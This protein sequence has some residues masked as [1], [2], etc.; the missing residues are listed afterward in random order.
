MVTI[1]HVKQRVVSLLQVISP[2]SVHPGLLS[3]DCI[4]VL[5]G[6]RQVQDLTPGG[7]IHVVETGT[8]HLARCLTDPCQ[9]KK[10]SSHQVQRPGPSCPQ[11]QHVTDC[12]VTYDRLLFLWTK[13]S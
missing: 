13:L 10:I 5:S 1:Q 11:H 12:P 6:P 8:L 4:N 2:D 7:G 9:V 3:L